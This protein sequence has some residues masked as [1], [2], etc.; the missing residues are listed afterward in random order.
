[1][2]PRACTGPG[3]GLRML[4][5]TISPSTCVGGS[6]SSSSKGLCAPGRTPLLAPPR[7]HASSIPAAGASSR[8]ER[9]TPSAPSRMQP[10]TGG[11]GSSRT[12]CSAAI[13]YS[14]YVSVRAHAC[15]RT[16]IHVHAC[17]RACACRSA[18]S[19]TQS[20]HAL[21]GAALGHRGANTCTH[22]SIGGAEREAG[23]KI[24]ASSACGTLLPSREC[25]SLSMP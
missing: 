10:G 15:A 12:A 8:R 24:G 21:M 1:M 13:D 19:C 11:G 18:S 20:M 4:A 17:M 3:A 9:G 14:K 23:V 22:A 2:Q 16:G 6:S 5:P 7:R 25:S